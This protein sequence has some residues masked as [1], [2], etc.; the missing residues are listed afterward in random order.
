MAALEGAILLNYNFI[1]IMDAA[2]ATMRGMQIQYKTEE[3]VQNLEFGG[4]KYFT[5]RYSDG[6]WEEY[7][8]GRGGKLDYT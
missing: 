6:A 5:Y 1:P 2:S 7:V 8:A 4:V 3:Y